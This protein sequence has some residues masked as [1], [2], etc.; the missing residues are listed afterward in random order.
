MMCADDEVYEKKRACRM[1]AL[2]QALFCFRYVHRRIAYEPMSIFV[3]RVEFF[4]ASAA[5]CIWRR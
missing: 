3:L 1:F 2:R 4:A 5:F